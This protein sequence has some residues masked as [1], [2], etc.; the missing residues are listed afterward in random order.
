M[1]YIANIREV[2]IEGNTTTTKDGISQLIEADSVESATTKLNNYYNS[3]G[4]ESISYT[5]LI[6]EINPTI[7]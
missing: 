7:S 1:L 6:K 5:I 3:L 2:K 4:T